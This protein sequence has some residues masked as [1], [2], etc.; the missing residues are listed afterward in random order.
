MMFG[1]SVTP[2]T[3]A[4]FFEDRKVFGE[5]NVVT[6]KPKNRLE[7]LRVR[8]RSH[9]FCGGF[10]HGDC[11]NASHLLLTVLVRNHLLPLLVRIFRI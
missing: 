8:V 5:T 1:G 11:K 2:S 10:R 7:S 9:R 4:G 6:G 3:I